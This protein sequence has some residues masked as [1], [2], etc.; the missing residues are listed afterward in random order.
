MYFFE[1]QAT[2]AKQL[3][4]SVIAEGVEEDYHLNYLKK[5]GCDMFQGYLISKPLPAD[6]A[7]NIVS[8]YESSDLNIF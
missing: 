3:G 8:F 4:L 6:E 2:M 5:H 1:P 7:A